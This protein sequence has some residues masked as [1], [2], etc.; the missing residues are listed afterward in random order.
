MDTKVGIKIE[1][2]GDTMVFAIEGHLDAS[3]VNAVNERATDVLESDF[4]KVVFDFS[5]LVYI[6]S[7]GLR[8]LLYVAKKTKSKGGKVALCS[9]NSNVQRIL[10]ISGLTRFLPVYDDREAALSATKS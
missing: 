6:S 9:V 7:A 10:D 3:M 5:N 8:V 2:V 1:E 4:V